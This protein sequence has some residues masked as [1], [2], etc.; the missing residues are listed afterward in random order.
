MECFLCT[1]AFGL[2]PLRTPIIIS[3]GHTLCMSCLTDIL[4]IAKS[5]TAVTCPMCRK[6]TPLSD[7]GLAGLP[8]N[9]AL[10]DVLESDPGA[11]ASS[12]NVNS[13][14][15]SHT[16]P[17]A[18]SS[19]K[20]TSTN[21]EAAT[22]AAAT[23]ATTATATTTPATT[24]SLCTQHGDSLRLY[25]HVCERAVCALCRE[26]SCRGHQVEA[27]QT[28]EEAM[29]MELRKFLKD[30]SA[31]QTEVQSAMI[32]LDRTAQGFLLMICLVD[33]NV[34]ILLRAMLFFLAMTRTY[35]LL[36]FFRDKFRLHSCSRE[37]FRNIS[38]SACDY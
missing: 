19:A 35:L 24:S 33:V 1:E 18:D 31:S 12:K 2:I 37:N 15:T 13:S 30:V 34:H 29:R 23:T 8:K 25:C 27:L 16:Q 32:E 28:T 17:T 4:A 22:T 11:R 10:L 14:S 9:Y 20:S 6:E 26:G 3:C 36:E 7:D 5:K 21:A 38:A